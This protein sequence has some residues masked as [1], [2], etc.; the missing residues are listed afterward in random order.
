MKRFSHWQ[1]ITGKGSDGLKKRSIY[2]QS[3]SWFVGIL[4]LLFVVC[5]GCS[6]APQ[7]IAAVAADNSGYTVIDAKGNSVC[8]PHKPQRILTA[9]LTYDAIV[10]GLVTP[11]HLVAMNILDTDAGISPLAQD[12]KKLTV[13]KVATLTNIPLEVI[14]STKPDLIIASD[15]TDAD[16]IASYRQLGYPVLVCKGPNSIAETYAAV[17]LIAQALQEQAAGEWICTEMDRQLAE[18]DAVLQKRTDHRPVGML[19]S[20]MTSYGGPGSMFHELCTRA[21]IENGIA[22]AGL[23]NGDFLSKELVVKVNLDFF[24]VSAPREID[25]YGGGRFR[26]EFLSDPALDGLPA[27]NHIL[28]IP[29]KYLYAASPN[30]V[31]AVKALAN[32]A[33]GDLFDMR[34]EHLIRG[35]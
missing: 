20:Q 13:P 34:D 6:Q 19:V 14:V 24:L 16:K 27:L 3:G 2:F 11:D 7:T 8:L 17:R 35:Y 22:K 23:K 15:W 32:A 21:R 31:Y 30:C 4:F 33:Y 1:M 10:A 25:M 28:S 29:D 12:A 9:N 26:E 18:I 5:S